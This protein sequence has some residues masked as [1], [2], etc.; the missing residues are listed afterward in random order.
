MLGKNVFLQKLGIK[1]STNTPVSSDKNSSGSNSASTPSNGDNNNENIYDMERDDEFDDSAALKAVE[2]LAS[3]VETIAP[4]MYLKTDKES[5]LACDVKLRGSKSGWMIK[6]GGSYKSWKRRFF[7]V[8]NRNIYYFPDEEKSE[9]LGAVR[10]E[11]ASGVMRADEETG[12]EFSFKILTRDRTL[13][14]TCDSEA[15]CQE[16]ISHLQAT[17]NFC[18][19]KEVL[20]SARLQGFVELIEG[21][22]SWSEKYCAIF[23]GYFYV[24]DSEDSV[25][26]SREFDLKGAVVKRVLPEECEGKELI[27]DS[28]Y[29]IEL[30]KLYDSSGGSS[31]SN[32]EDSPPQTARLS[33]KT[34][35]MSIRKSLG[36][37]KATETG[38]DPSNFFAQLS[39]QMLSKDV[40]RFRATD[41][42]SPIWEG[43]LHNEVDDVTN[44]WATNN[45]LMKGWLYRRVPKDNRTYIWKLEYFVVSNTHLYFFQDEEAKDVLGKVNIVGKMV[46]KANNETRRPFTFKIEHTST[47]YLGAQCDDECDCWI[48]VLKEISKIT[49]ANSYTKSGYLTKQGGSYK[50]WK[51]RFCVLKGTYLYYFKDPSD[52]EPKGR[53]KLAGQ[54]I[55]LLTPREAQSIVEKENVI[56]IY[57]SERTWY[58]YAEHEQEASEWA[59]VL[60]KAALLF[61]SNTLEVNCNAKSNKSSSGNEQFKT[62]QEAVV[63]AKDL[64]RILIKHGVYTEQV[65]IKK[66]LILEGSGHVTIQSKS[67][68]LMMEAAAACKIS[69][70]TIKQTGEKEMCGVLVKQGNVI[71]EHCEISSESGCGIECQQECQITLTNC[72]VSDCKLHGIWLKGTSSGLFENDIITENG[73]DGINVVGDSDMTIRQSQVF[74]NS[75]NGLYINTKGRVAID[76]NEIC[77]NQWDGVSVNSKDVTCKIYDNQIYENCGFGIYFARPEEAEGV[78]ID[79]EVYGNI[80]AQ[81]KV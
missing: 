60:R 47:I 34:A 36:V 61:G 44:S 78:A 80:K 25:K 43:V 64:D 71:M 77:Q 33:M 42:D 16:W 62:I 79:N 51:T 76:N 24:F 23:N 7:V 1:K 38:A 29:V 46:T 48:E 69:N 30:A 32:T 6:R 72:Q 17:A 55:R 9:S 63:K 68:P 74:L 58:L 11:K 45:A 67:T 73:W 21:A 18:L 14:C 39:A 5:M 50:S 27:R 10:L 3:G 54:M 12:R 28:D 65:I 13:Y 22:S 20:S 66:S 31:S 70:M 57:T 4:T 35:R 81:I 52:K 2:S 49:V 75:Y 41:E 37:K 40:I 15:L 26:P 56:Q 8:V 19:T 59:I 53:V